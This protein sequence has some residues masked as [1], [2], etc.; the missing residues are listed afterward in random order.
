M[1]VISA[2]EL[3]GAESAQLKETVALVM[4]KQGFQ[5]EKLAEEIKHVLMRL[6]R[7]RRG[8]Q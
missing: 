3:T 7:N 4:K 8:G 1:I 6:N 2:K 5:G